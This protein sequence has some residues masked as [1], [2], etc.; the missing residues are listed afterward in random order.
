M[1]TRANDPNGAT[2]NADVTPPA[3]PF[4]EWLD[5]ACVAEAVA[6]V[7]SPLA[8]KPQLRKAHRDDDALLLEL[9]YKAELLQPEVFKT[10]LRS[11][12]GKLPFRQLED[13]LEI[14]R[15]WFNPQPLQSP[16]LP[17]S[18]ESQETEAPKALE[19]T[20]VTKETKVTEVT[21]DTKDTE[22][23]IRRP[24]M[25][26]NQTANRSQLVEL[27]K[28][29]SETPLNERSTFFLAGNVMA[30]EKHHGEFNL[31]LRKLAFDAATEKMR[32][33]K[34]CKLFAAYL[35]AFEKVKTPMIRNIIVTA[36][37][38]V[39]GL[40]LRDLPDIPG[41][42]LASGNYK[43]ILALHREMS[44]LSGGKEYF[45]SR[46]SMQEVAHGKVNRYEVGNVCVLLEVYGQIKIVDRGKPRQGPG[47]G[48]A[49]YRYI[50]PRQS[51][52]ATDDGCPF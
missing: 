13:L 26:A 17:C 29:Y 9:E 47:K 31:E 5:D 3:E 18:A 52:V 28:K 6:P 32:P 38:N 22:D 50:G 48:A 23:T 40:G 11:A 12:H 33:D 39:A 27:G 2:A 41:Y 51:N 34:R 14:N 1:N 46:R 43:R 19:E 21:E 8:A 10:E 42:S 24:I 25:M 44:L 36:I 45:L 37:S 20:D 7:S 15:R 49:R 35:G 16:W 30:M 4:P